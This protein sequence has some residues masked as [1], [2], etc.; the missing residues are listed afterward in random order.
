[1]LLTDHGKIERVTRGL[2][3]LAK[4][5]PHLINSSKGHEIRSKL[6]HNTSSEN[7]YST[8]ILI[9]PLSISS[10]SIM[11]S[12]ESLR[13]IRYLLIISINRSI[14]DGLRC[15]PVNIRSINNNH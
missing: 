12:R 6:W 15:N 1:M 4:M 5:I 8:S 2:I 11:I 3:P 13:E 14:I 9:R 10:L 7:S